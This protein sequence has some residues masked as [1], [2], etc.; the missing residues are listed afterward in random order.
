MLCYVLT[1]ISACFSAS[2]VSKFVNV[3]MAIRWI[4]HTWNQ[5]NSETIFK[6]FRKYYE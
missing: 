4:T 3:L 2:N 6:C 5:V 1:K